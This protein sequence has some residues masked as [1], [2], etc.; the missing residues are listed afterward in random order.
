VQD[1]IESSGGISIWTQDPR[2]RGIVENVADA[3]I[4][5]DTAG[6]I[7]LF[8][9]AA[10]RL[11][12]YSTAQ[13][14][15][16]DVSLLAP[17]TYRHR[18]QEGMSR[19]LETGEA[20]IIGIGREVEGLRRDGTTFPMYISVGEVRLPG[21][22]GFIGVLH[23]LSD[24]KAAERELAA[25]RGY[26][27]DIIDSMPSLLVGLD[28]EGCVTHWNRVAAQVCKVPA[29][30]A[31]GLGIGELFPF[32]ADEVEAVKRA[33]RAREPFKRERLPYPV[34][35]ETRFADVVVYPLA[36]EGTH[37]AVMRM[38]DVTERIRMEE[39]MV[40]TEKMMSVGGV[41]AGM[42]HEINNPLGV[43]AQGCQNLLR[44][45]S[46]EIPAN[47]AAAEALGVDLGRIRA[48]LEE[49]EFYRFLSGMQE[50]VARASQIVSD[51][52]A[53][54][55]RSTSSFVPVP[56][57]ELIEEVLRLAGHDYDLKKSYDFRR[58][59]I[60]LDYGPGSDEIRCD[61]TGIEQVLFNLLKNAAQAMA[62]ASPGRAP[63]ITLRLRDEGARVRLEV[64]DNGPG[65]GDEVRH[66]LFE[67]FF[68]TKPVGIGTGLGLSV[69]YFI[70]T[71]QHR[72]TMEV[73]TAPGEGA[74]FIIRLPRQGRP[75]AAD[76]TVAV[77]GGGRPT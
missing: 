11:F 69:A 74:R 72:G 2:I 66:R 16:R 64:E 55:R 67:P 59:Q 68:T 33:I 36:D 15:G 26:L 70:V 60:H 27:R 73:V 77:G 23:D 35:G 17:P 4:V 29:E 1:S 39:T 48:Y 12:G 71:E 40:Q 51:M 75:Y 9:P 50:A 10:E 6:R 57:R 32:L 58:I 43:I 53:F 20:H 24:Q 41:A 46:D 49:R 21:F 37:G 18:H 13:V 62:M 52:L 34:G 76:D 14:M 42:A 47:L 22:H 31:V 44:R 7:E 38:D 45:V 61:R 19:Y 54:S 65:M 3:V 63:S 30:E 5:I 25:T 56:L 28:P 8:N